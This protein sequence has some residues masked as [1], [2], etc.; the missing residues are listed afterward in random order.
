MGEFLVIWE[1]DISADTSAEAA[2]ETLRIQRDPDSQ[3]TFFTVVDKNTG[4]K[5]TVDLEYLDESPGN[6]HGEN[7]QEI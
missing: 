4:E 7:H 6:D 5:G 2:A 1:I 3:T